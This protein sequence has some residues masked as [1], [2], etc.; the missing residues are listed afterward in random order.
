MKGI[1][2]KLSN[3]PIKV[4]EILK[5]QRA[6]VKLKPINILAGANISKSKINLSPEPQPWTTITL[7]RQLSTTQDMDL[8][9]LL[10]P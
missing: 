7:K 9:G 10:R 3:V 5:Y 8:S 6:Q 1:S 4:E 2:K